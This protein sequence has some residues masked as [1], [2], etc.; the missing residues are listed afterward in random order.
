MGPQLR[1][2][3]IHGRRLIQSYR[4]YHRN[5]DERTPQKIS[6]RLYE[7]SVD[8]LPT[9][10]GYYDKTPFSHDNS[11]ILAAAIAFDRDWLPVAS[12]SPLKLGYFEWADVVSG[13]PTFRQF[14]ETTTWS[15][16]QGCML[17]WFPQDPNR[18][19][20]YNRIVDGRYGSI[21]QDVLQGKTMIYYTMP[22]YAVDPFGRTG[23]SLNFSRLERLRPGYGYSNI[24]DKTAGSLYPENDGVWLVDLQTGECRMVVTLRQLAKLMPLPSMED[25]AHYVN[26]LLFSPDGNRVIFL[27]LWVTVD[28]RR[29]NRLMLYD[30]DEECLQ[31]LDDRGVASHFNWLSADK[32]LCFRYP[33]HGK[34]AYYL[35]KLSHAMSPVCIPLETMSS[36]PDGHPSV[37]PSGDWIVTDT[38]PDGIRDLHL[39]IC[40]TQKDV[41][42]EAGKFYSPCRYRGH[43][44]CDLHPR[45]DRMG[46]RVCFDS[47]HTGKRAIYVLDMDIPSDEGSQA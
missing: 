2:L 40:S 26:H 44:R 15:W 35:Y 18:L 27:H 10:F 14:G 43:I 45:W 46:R 7:M 4:N 20:L 11:R 47:T 31:V 39:Y 29:R 17:Q 23:V 41:I 28:G 13:K 30:L 38:Y 42:L 8:G 1:T 25:A 21:V 9:Y 12:A 22:I 24:T 16:Q 5:L 6:G 36:L 32:I 34:P 3:R 33:M 19:V 37:C